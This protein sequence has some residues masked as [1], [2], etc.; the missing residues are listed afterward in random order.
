MNWI[1]QNT[2]N[3]GLIVTAVVGG[4]VLWIFGSSAASRY[5]A[6]KDEYQKAYEQSKTFEKLEPYPTREHL[7]SKKLAVQEYGEET[8]ALQKAFQEYRPETLEN[9]SPQVFS[10]ALKEANK[11]TR[12]AFG[13]EI[14]IPEAYFCGFEIY[15][16]ALPTGNATG[17]LNHQLGVVK[18]LM[19]N[20]AEAEVSKLISLHRVTLPEEEN[21]AFEPDKKQ[22]ARALPMEVVFKGS[23]ESVRQFLSSLVNDKEHYLVVRSVRINSEKVVPPRKSDVRFEGRAPG[24]KPAGGGGAPEGAPNFNELFNPTGD[25]AAPDGAAEGEGEAEGE[26]EVQ[27]APAPEPVFVAGDSSRILAQVLGQEELEVFVRVDLLIFLEPKK[28]P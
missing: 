15:R 23:E 24:G 28:L 5:D 19:L 16:N 6:A 7:Q 21:K 9:I 17:I 13:D 1:K 2:F 11:E 10:S 25:G 12:A 20:L 4:I 27:P 26:A 8:D 18:Q 22:V 3:F 14:A